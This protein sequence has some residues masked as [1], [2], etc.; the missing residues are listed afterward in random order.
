MTKE[1]V[2]QFWF[3]YLN[4]Q[5]SNIKEKFTIFCYNDGSIYLFLI[6][7]GTIEQTEWAV[8]TTVEDKS[9]ECMSPFQQ[10]DTPIFICINSV[11]QDLKAKYIF[12]Y[13]G[14]EKMIGKFEKEKD[15]QWRIQDTE[16][17][18]AGGGARRRGANFS[19]G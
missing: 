12:S 15:L 5:K 3:K 6:N 11:E 16:D 9:G 10:W 8:R 14:K 1:H 4:Q 17:I 18:G 19:F 7:E 2:R 13:Q